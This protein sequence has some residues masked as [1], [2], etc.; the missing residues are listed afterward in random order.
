MNLEELPVSLD[1]PTPAGMGAGHAWRLLVVDDQPI[2]RQGLRLILDRVPDLRVCAEAEN[3]KQALTAI[4]QATPDLLIA[5]IDLLKGGGIQLIRD[6]RDRHPRLPILIFS[7]YDE[8]IYAQRMLSVGA[9]GYIMK[10]SD[11]SQLLIAIR[12]LLQGGVYVSQSVGNHIIQKTINGKQSTVVNEIENLSNRE[13]Q[14][15][16]MIGKGL[17]TRE[18]AEVLHLSAK[19]VESHRQRIKLKLNLKSGVQ[20]VQYAVRWNPAFAQQ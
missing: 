8:D 10:Q 13:L 16:Q 3:V 5:E 2:C 15:L 14:I 4:E 9:S 18:T 11:S 12:R 6:V 20:L 19:T 7:T 17:S 1:F